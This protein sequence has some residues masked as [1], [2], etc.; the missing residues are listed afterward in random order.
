M[1]RTAMKRFIAS[2]FALAIPAG[3][4]F[5]VAPE[6]VIGIWLFDEGEGDVL[7]DV[8]GNGNDGTIVNAQWI[9]GVRGKALKF[10]GSGYV[11][12]PASETLNS[13]ENE[14]S[15]LAWVRV[16]AW[17]NWARIVARGNWT[18]AMDKYQFLLLLGGSMGDVGFCVSIKG[19]RAKY[20][21]KPVLELNKWHHVA[22]VSDGQQVKLYVD[23]QFIG[24]SPSA[25][26]INKMVDEPLTIG[27][28]YANG[29][30]ASFLNG[31]VDEVAIFNRALSDD[32]VKELMEGLGQLVYPVDPRSKLA[33]TWGEVKS[34]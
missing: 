4:A 6:G 27:C 25:A 12:I 13:I 19:E 32:E 30:R 1:R 18:P 21:G 14:I 33:V 10:D 24:A 22:G 34:R 28:G 11:E 17:A 7:K 15:V 20:A 9:E 29:S 31:A 26:P 16:D 5:G 8:S 23:G 2:M 3:L